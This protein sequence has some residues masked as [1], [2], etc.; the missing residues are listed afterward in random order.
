[1]VAGIKIFR[2]AF[3]CPRHKK[4]VKWVDD[5]HYR[6]PQ[7]HW[8]NY[9]PP[10][11]TPTEYDR[12]RKIEEPYRAAEG[13][14]QFNIDTAFFFKVNNFL[15][16]EFH[17]PAPK[18]EGPDKDYDLSYTGLYKGVQG[19]FGK[20]RGKIHLQNY[21]GIVTL[22]H[23]FTHH[24]AACDRLKVSDDLSNLHGADFLVVEEMLLKSFATARKEK[25]L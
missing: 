17:Y 2:P 6:C 22:I 19:K 12:C 24:V 14:F 4:P 20:M 16:A 8:N 3:L 18:L 25:S 13:G 9:V 15:A 5:N 7:C 21:A 23:E 1:M 11:C 10:F